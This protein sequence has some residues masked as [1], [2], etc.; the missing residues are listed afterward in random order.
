MSAGGHERA[1]G[2]G[3]ERWR[4]I[5]EEGLAR[6]LAD[7]PVRLEALR[8]A[9][10]AFGEDFD[11]DVFRED[12]ESADPATVTRVDPIEAN[13]VKL[14]NAIS[15]VA[16]LGLALAG[17]RPRAGGPSVRD[18]LERLMKDGGISA[19]RCRRLIRLVRIRNELQ[20]EYVD[21]TAEDLHEAVRLLLRELPGF[22]RDYARWLT[23]RGIR[24]PS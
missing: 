23:R 19:E 18:D 9:T 17:L 1:G 11:L 4:P 8:Y 24:L 22:V 6:R 5:Y 14:V 15:E 12:F 20:H 13:F 10:G 7:V 3:A 2:S 21:V 16:R